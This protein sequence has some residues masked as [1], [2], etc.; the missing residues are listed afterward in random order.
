MDKRNLWT[1]RRGLLAALLTLLLTAGV[2]YGAREAPPTGGGALPPILFVARQNLATRDTIFSDELGPAGQFGTGL[3]KF[4]PGSRLALR[5]PDGTVTLYTTP[6]LVDVQSPDISFDGSRILFAGARSLDRDDPDYGWRIYEL[7]VDGGG[8]RQLTFSDRAITIPNAGE[9]FNEREYGAYDDLFPAYLAD[10]RIVF[11]SSRYPTRAHYDNR[12]T[13]N[14]YVMDGDGN[15]LHRITSERAGLLHPTPLPDG[16]ILV[17]RWWNNFNQPSAAGIYNRIDNQDSDYLLPDG[18]L[19]H[20]NADEPFNPATGVLP[21]GDPVRDAPNTWHLMS[22]NPDGSDLQRFVWSAAFEWALERD[23]G[24]FDTYTAAQPAPF[25]V[26]DDL[27]VAFTSQTDS[28]MVHTT[29]ETGIRVARPG[30]AMMW[31]NAADAIAGLTYEQAWSGDESGPYA[32]HPWG[33][34]DGRILYSQSRTDASLPGSGTYSENGETFVLQGGDQRYELY[35]MALDGSAKTPV[36]LNLAAVGLPNAHVLDAKPVVVRSGWQALPDQFTSVAGDDPLTMNVPNTLPEYSFSLQGPGDIATATIHNPNIYA[37]PGLSTPFINNSPPPG[38]VAT[39]E[40]WID[41]N[42]FSG[43][44][45]YNDYPQPC[46]D[47]RADNQLRAVLWDSVPVTPEGAFHGDHSGRRARVLCPAR[48]RRHHRAPL[49]ARLR[50]YCPGQRLGASRRDGDLRRLPPGARQRLGGGNH[51]RGA[52][53]GDK[54]GAVRNR[55]RQQLSY[56]R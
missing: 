16:R 29:L 3:P 8:F 42:Q 10:G 5:A 35:T 1:G 36:A 45:C 25:L 18:T 12:R 53:R 22:L 49:G 11:N 54:R 4:A 51:G 26:N 52:G 43:A 21:G 14:L 28:T 23:D 31:A 48:P 55:E 7:R 24:H 46:D 15:G 32:L 39:V 56:G 19:V 6:G 37:N 33:L 2:A 50:R 13:F 30:V 34:P 9:F 47:F 17:S 41:A 44:S 20:G 40:I 38:S 27:V